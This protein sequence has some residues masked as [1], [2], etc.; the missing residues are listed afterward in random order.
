VGG[1][2]R[3]QKGALMMIEPP[4]NLRR[5]RIFEIND[6][7]FVAVK[8]P[9]LKGLDGTMGHAGIT[10]DRLRINAL[11]VKARKQ[12][13]RSRTIEATI[14][15]AETDLFG[16]RQKIL[17]SGKTERKIHPAK[18]FK[19]DVRL[20]IVKRKGGPLSRRRP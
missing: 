11:A 18:P 17:A 2:G 12:S 8:Q 16:V 15:E 13:G 5:A 6:H 19:M 3:R 9:L 14:V 20:L 10:K 7:I 4:G 1:V